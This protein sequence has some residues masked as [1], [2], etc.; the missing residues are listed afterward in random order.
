MRPLSRSL[1]LS[2]LL[3]C[4]AQAADQDAP[5][6]TV[7]QTNFSQAA[8]APVAAQ[9]RL[10]P[11]AV[12]APAQTSLALPAAVVPAP[13]AVQA[14]VARSA[15]QAPEPGH[16]TLVQTLSA[17]AVDYKPMAD[18]KASEAARADFESRAQLGA[19]QAGDD[20]PAAAPGAFGDG[21]SGL[22]RGAPGVVFE[23]RRRLS[24]S[25]SVQWLDRSRRNWYFRAIEGEPEARAE[26]AYRLD[27]KVPYELLEDEVKGAAERHRIRIDDVAAVYR[28]GSSVWG[29]KGNRPGDLDLLVVVDGK[30]EGAS[31]Q[32]SESL[33]DVDADNPRSFLMYWTDEK[34]AEGRLPLNVTVVSREFISEFRKR[35]GAPES[36]APLDLGDLTTDW[37]NSVLTYGEDALASMTPTPYQILLAAKGT[38]RNAG[39]FMANFIFKEDL[40]APQSLSVPSSKKVSEEE[41][42]KL[43]PKIFLRQLEVRLRLASALELAGHPADLQDRIVGDPRPRFADYFMGRAWPRLPK[44]EPKMVEETIGMSNEGSTLISRAQSVI[45]GVPAQARWKQW[46]TNALLSLLVLGGFV[47]MLLL[48]AR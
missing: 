26:L 28:Y 11:S 37:G 24:G 27:R 42:N 43:V 34:T 31:S 40:R 19:S 22:A 14:P 3:S 18:G 38:E 25:D 29:A 13:T 1:I 7:P 12:V 21:A 17:A 16:P 10:A 2:L 33:S 20:A 8:P 47:G 30:A 48:G 4:A 44:V 35:G 9:V 36:L 6:P 23:A 45:T 5:V 15:A 46:L 41:N 32:S 39:G